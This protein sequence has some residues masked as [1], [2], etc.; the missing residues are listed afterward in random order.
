MAEYWLKAVAGRQT[1]SNA[2]AHAMR[3]SVMTD[4]LFPPAQRKNRPSAALADG[5][6]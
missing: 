4:S 3:L 2:A 1:A 5:Q 6:L